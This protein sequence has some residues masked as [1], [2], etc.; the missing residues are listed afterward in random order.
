[1]TKDTPIARRGFMLVLSSPSGVGKTTITRHVLDLETEL[2]LSISVTTRPK[3]DSEKEGKD[4]Y[5][6]DESTFSQMVQKKQFLEH[7]HVY[8]YH[9][10]TPIAS[11]QNLLAAGKDVL[12]DIDWQG[13]QQLKQI[14]M[15][16][17]V[18]VFLLPPT[19]ETL[20][21]RLRYRGEDSEEVIHMR[22]S[23]SAAEISHWAEYD[24]IIINHTLPESIQEV[25]SILQAERL[26]RRR[27]VGLAHFVNS[28]RGE[29]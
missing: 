27:Q 15:N 4:Y 22:M 14:S 19:M 6:V 16:D 20:E 23:K 13:T 18:S 17:L 9:Y 29:D 28:L 5:F 7:A 12:F 2:E 26:K 25:R 24:Y 21:T 10:G 8:G 11:I 3:R 1:M